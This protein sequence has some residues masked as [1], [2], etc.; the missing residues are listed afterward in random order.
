MSD[1]LIQKV[2]RWITLD[3]WPESDPAFV[4]SPS[5]RRAN[6]VRLDFRRD[7][8]IKHFRPRSFDEVELAAELLKS[9]AP[10]VITLESAE[11][12]DKNRMIDFLLGVTFAL[13]GHVRKVAPGVYL[14]SP[15]GIPIEGPDPEK[16]PE[17]KFDLMDVS[18]SSPG[19]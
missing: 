12:S 13:D 1:G 16:A 10:V 5:E 4:R 2:R 9:G 17:S 19:W 8:V 7:P 6:I 18:D 14:F 3:D 11:S 15:A